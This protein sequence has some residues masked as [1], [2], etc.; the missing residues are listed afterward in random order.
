MSRLYPCIFIFFFFAS[1]LASQP[2][3]SPL[4][5]A[6][7]EINFEQSNWDAILDNY[8]AAGNGERLL[9]TV[10]I[11]GVSFDSVGVRYRGGGTYHPD[12]PKNPLN[13]KLDHVKNQDYE[14]IEVLKLSNGAKDPSFLREVLSL[15]AARQ[16]MEAP[17]A[18][19][20]RVFVN[21]AYHGLYANV[22]SINA[23]FFERALQLD[24]DAPRFECNPSYDF[25][26]VPQNPPFGCSV[27]H[28]ASL[29][30]LGPG[31]ACYFDHYE[32]QSNTGWEALIA[33]AQTL[34]N[35][36]A[37][38]DQYFD[39]DRMLWWSVFNNLFVNL[40]SY[41]GAG[42]RNYYLG[43]T[44]DGRF[45]P[46]PDDLNES[47]AK[48]PWVDVDAAAGAQPP[49]SFFQQLSPWQGED[50]PQKPLLQAL[51]GQATWRRMYLAHYRTMVQ[52][53][54]SSGW[55]ENRAGQL[56]DFISDE[57]QSDPNNLYSFQDFEDNLTT[58]VVD[59]YDGY[60]AY[61][62]LEL[63]DG[64]VAWL[65]SLP[66]WQYQPPTLSNPG[67]SPAVPAPGENAVFTVE[68]DEAADVWLGF[69]SNV[70]EVFKYYQL[71]DDGLHGDGAAGDLVYGVV[72]PVNA[73]GGQYFFYAEN[74]LAG[75]FLPEKAAHVYYSLSTAANVVINELMARNN[76]TVADQDGEYDDWIELYNNSSQTIDLSGW[77]LTDDPLLPAKWTF[78]NGVFL[79]PGAYLVVW[80]DNDTGQAGLHASFKLSAGGEQLQLLNPNLQVADEVVFPPLAED[81]AFSRC[82][83]GTGPFSTNE[84][85]FASGNDAAC[86]TPTR[87][88]P[89]EML[90]YYPNPAGS[91]VIFSTKNTPNG[92]L[93]I[94]DLTGR[95]VVRVA[96][97]GSIALDVSGWYPGLYLVLFNG[98]P[99][100]KLVV[101]ESK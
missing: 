19:Y 34:A 56:Q 2:L 4:V 44:A 75:Q 77:H 13:I 96:L 94:T 6:T 78:P 62:L 28:G 60:D 45:V 87:E 95:P 91:Q 20:A 37:A 58:A 89:L 39:L 57:L 38:T 83:N 27:G 25:D 33:A 71:S 49:L 21:G 18:N 81:I 26:A 67:H 46:V 59:S 1:Q 88:A 31:V 72:L 32:M 100:G 54:V 15:E 86:A 65:Q 10:E 51:L 41:L 79:D 12:N 43:S 24:P 42:A 48:Y 47:F 69:R 14:G 36:P 61:G 3:Y 17:R 82:P 68:L 9:A 70:K 84:P 63:M 53:L 97:S 8:Y 64:R 73:G 74:D 16:F 98:R 93:L 92:A 11:N 66:E 22:E 35:N 50:D 5:I 90:T 40:D 80:A 99:A 76:S 85:S 30:Y 52:E 55:L 23:S 101:V 7:I 29:E